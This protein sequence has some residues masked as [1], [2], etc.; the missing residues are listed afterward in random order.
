MHLRTRVQSALVTILIAAAAAGLS[1]HDFWLE[2]S[3]FEPSVDEAVRIHLRIGER[4]AGESLARNGSLIEKFVVVGPTGEKPVLGRDGMDPAGLL[5]LDT[6]GIWFVGYRSK[7]S[8]VEL[9]PD[10]FEEYLRAEGLER[11]IDDRAARRES[12]VPG[13]EKFS[14]SVKSLLRFG[15]DQAVHGFDRVLGMTLEFVLEADPTRAAGG[16]VPIRLL[17]DGRP[18]AGALVVAYR[19]DPGA[20][21]SGPAGSSATNPAGPASTGSAPSAY[22][23]GW[24]CRPAGDGWTLAPQSSAY[25][26]RRRRERSRLGKC[27]DGAY[28]PGLAVSLKAL[29]SQLSALSFQLSAKSIQCLVEANGQVLRLSSEC[30]C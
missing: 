6:P 3:T 13:R 17:R 2:P 19:K 4:F 28:V 16:K 15:G 18:L 14:R 27:V 30:S 21:S 1:A 12:Q 29:S 8:G 24:T 5:R 22:R 20:A 26:T 23:Q 25:G 7:S 10:K 9:A 11:I